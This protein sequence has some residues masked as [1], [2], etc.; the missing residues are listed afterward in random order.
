MLLQ[1][2]HEKREQDP[3]GAGGVTDEVDPAAGTGSGLAA[4][5]RAPPSGAG[6][7]SA[8]AGSRT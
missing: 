7:G 4:T 6:G 5:H 8:G 3:A 2:V 1:V